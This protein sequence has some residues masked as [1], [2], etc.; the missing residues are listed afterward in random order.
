MR[1]FSYLIRPGNRDFSTAKYQSTRARELYN[2]VNSIARA[3][4]FH[5]SKREYGP[6]IYDIPRSY[7]YDVTVKVNN[8]YSYMN[9][10]AVA[11]HL[12]ANNHFELDECFGAKA[13]QQVVRLVAQ[14]WA[15]YFQLLKAYRAGRVPHRPSPPGY[16]KD[17]GAVVYSSQMLSRRSL[18]NGQVKPTPS[19]FAGSWGLPP[20][21]APESVRSARLIP[22][23][24]GQAFELEVLYVEKPPEEYVPVEVVAG[25]DIGVCNL[26]TI[27]F[28]DFSD[29]LI[30]PG[31]QLKH[32]NQSFNYRVDKHRSVVAKRNPGS[33]PKATKLEQ[34]WQENRRRRLYHE[35]TTLNNRTVEALKIRGVNKVVIG[36]NAGIK[37]GIN[38]GR[39]N[40]REF[41]SLP[42]KK[43]VDNLSYKLKTAGIDVIF[44][45]ES[46]TSKSS[47]VDNDPLPSY[48]DGPRPTFSGRRSRRGLYITQHGCRI[49]AD[50]NGA[51]NIIRKHAPGF[52]SNVDPTA[53]DAV[54]Y[55]VRRL[56]HL[57]VPYTRL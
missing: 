19:A 53:R 18:K 54:V 39:K 4:F 28:D 37:Q 51:Y 32:I 38:I 22:R 41:V 23:A 46:Y 12:F 21:I 48:G 42:L 57:P 44:V 49:N 26:Y 5:N 8:A 35:Y 13:A 16:R 14:S 6:Y 55:P 17:Y 43:I 15:S 1:R 11:Q 31:T 50:L 3:R 30:V 36:W 56:D 24:G 7:N 33:N 25:I 10:W 52:T 47:F 34:R 29:G 9:L 45:E 40:N 2:V 27:A 20:H